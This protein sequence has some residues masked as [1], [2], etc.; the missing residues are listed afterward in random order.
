MS[1]GGALVR[2]GSAIAI[3][4]A[5]LT[6]A[7][8]RSVRRPAPLGAVGERVSILIPAR[9][10]ETT[11]ERTVRSA[12]GQRGIPD[13]EVIV[14]DDGSTDATGAIL[15]TID[16]PR[17]QVVT[18]P[19]ATPPAGW[20]GKTWA[21][22]RLG[23]LATGT[24]LAFVDADVELGPDAIA[25]CV[26]E[27]RSAGLALLAP[28]PRQEAS[29]ALGQLVQPLLTWSWM[30]TIPLAAAERSSRESLSAANGQLLVID[31]TVYRA[32]DGHDSVAGDVIEDVA[33]MRAV[34]RVGGTAATVDGSHLATCTMY[35][36]DRALVD[37]YAK[38][39]W[40]AFGGPVGT[41]AVNG[42][43]LTAFTLPVAAALVASDRRTRAIGAAGYA[44]A[45]ASRA[46]VAAR[47]GAPVPLALTHP[48]SILAFSVLNV[49]S[50]VRHRRGTNDWKGRAVTPVGA[51]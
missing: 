9:D 51:P 18:A 2:A 6:M 37:G 22:Q 25:A 24:V 31:S 28:Y 8:L 15:A 10:E 21:C 46:A 47:T 1:A 50:W 49:V 42:I 16:D 30:A 29:G 7:N 45:V 36:N 12:L 11:I 33:L 39:L 32:L 38:S 34:K 4:S 26:H 48:A 19:D 44:A 35:A 5:A 27:L 23:E 13:L 3:G 43:L 40:S 20:L 14:L 41:V 17:L